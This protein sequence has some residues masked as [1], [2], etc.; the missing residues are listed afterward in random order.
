M[1]LIGEEN[2]VRFMNESNDDACP[3]YSINKK[4]IT[5]VD[6]VNIIEKMFGIKA[7]MIQN[8]KREKIE[9]ICKEILKIEGVSTRQLARVTGLSINLIW[10]L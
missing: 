1:D 9:H 10:R 2:F 4:A 5:D 6:V 3:D 8:E 7:L